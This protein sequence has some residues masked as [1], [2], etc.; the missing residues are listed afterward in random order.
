MIEVPIILNKNSDK[1]KKSY[2]IILQHPI[3]QTKALNIAAI[4]AGVLK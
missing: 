2:L 1:V 4:T 3:T